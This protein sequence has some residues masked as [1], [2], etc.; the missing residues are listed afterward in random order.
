MSEEKEQ[1][2]AD[3]I[4][5][6]NNLLDLVKPTGIIFAENKDNKIKSKIYLKE[7]Q[8]V[9]ANST[10][11][12]ARFGDLMIKKGIITPKELNTALKLQE[13]HPDKPLIGNILVE[14]G[15]I[16]ERVVPN[17][18]FHQIEL[19][20]YEILIWPKAEITFVEGLIES[21][22]EYKSPISETNN[23]SRLY[24]D[25]SQL[26]DTR[27]FVNSIGANLTDLINIRRYFSNPDAVPKR[28]LKIYPKQ[29]SFDH[30]KILRSIDG[31]NSLL[32]III[33][34]DL[35]YFRTYQ[36][37]FELVSE[38][39]IAVSENSEE[40]IV[41]NSPNG[42]NFNPQNRESNDQEKTELNAQ[43]SDTQVIQPNYV[44]TIKKYEQI[45]KNNREEINSLRLKINEYENTSMVFSEEV[46]SRIGRLPYHKKMI[47]SGIVKNILDMVEAI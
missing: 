40:K 29:L 14:M 25:L 39:V 47:L 34:S 36:I 26:S 44:E 28:V 12:R 9:F 35:D 32:D 7:G 18:L 24:S 43:I 42:S 31:M 27:S 23:K 15:L 1:S 4:S 6:I 21:D 17:L 13:E 38:K 19:V 45:I 33:L 20:I 37:L 5:I 16:S 41:S 3:L 46:Y 30:R 10:M 2:G 11:Y 22:N 8:I